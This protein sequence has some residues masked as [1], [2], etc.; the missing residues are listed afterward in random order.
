MACKFAAF[1]G[2][3]SRMRTI[4]SRTGWFCADERRLGRRSLRPSTGGI[5]LLGS[6]ASFQLSDA[7]LELCHCRLELCARTTQAI[8]SRTSGDCTRIEDALLLHPGSTPMA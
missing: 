3:R 8:R 7:S 6:V 4:C 1:A 5:E 2:P